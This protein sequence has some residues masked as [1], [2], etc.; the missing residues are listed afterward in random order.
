MTYFFAVL[1]VV[2]C[3]LL[4]SVASALGRL[5]ETQEKRLRLQ[6]DNNTRMNSTVSKLGDA[7]ASMMTSG[8]LQG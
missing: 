4:Y 8:R 3:F 5:S 2:I 7:A 1:G 6:I